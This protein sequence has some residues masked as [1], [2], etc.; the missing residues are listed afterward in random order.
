MVKYKL[1]QCIVEYRSLSI[2][3]S[4]SDTISLLILVAFGKCAA[5]AAED[6][7][8][9]SVE[10]SCITAIIDSI[11]PCYNC[12]CGIVK[13]LAKKDMCPTGKPPGTFRHV[14]ESKSEPNFTRNELLVEWLTIDTINDFNEDCKEFGECCINTS[15]LTI[16]ILQGILLFWGISFIINVHSLFL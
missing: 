14:Q 8:G 7:L 10:M 2:H 3:K 15:K 11:S 4:P 16:R 5:K 1:I 13:K 12:I 6:G 9:R